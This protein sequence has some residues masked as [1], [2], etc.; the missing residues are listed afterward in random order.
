MFYDNLF[1]KLYSNKVKY[2]LAGGYALNIYGINRTTYD[3]DIIVELSEQN[4]KKLIKVL[5]DLDM[6]SQLPV[7]IDDIKSKEIRNSWINERNMIVFSLYQKDKPYHVIDI[8]IKELL[9]F[10]GIY[11]RRKI[12]KYNDFEIYAINKDDLINLKSIA[13]RKKDL[14]DIEELNK[15]TKQ[16]LINPR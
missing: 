11:K 14:N 15:K 5:K 7:K 16:R 8:F 3:I 12:I 1:Y 6:V 9:N 13:G 4:L 2:V 10:D